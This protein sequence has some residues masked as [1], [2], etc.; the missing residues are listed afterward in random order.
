MSIRSDLVL[1]ARREL[2]TV[3]LVAGMCGSTQAR[4]SSAA[5]S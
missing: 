2:G 3:G 1:G 4:S 5:T